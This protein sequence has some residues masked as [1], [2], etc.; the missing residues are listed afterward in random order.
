MWGGLPS[1][2][3]EERRGATAAFLTVFGVLAAHTIL[4]TARDALFLARLPASQLPWVYLL[5]AAIAVALAQT[6][7]GGARRTSGRYGLS[8]LL[9][10]FSIPTFVFWATA[11]W[12]SPAALYALYVWTGLVGSLAVLEFYMVL[13]ETYTVTQAKRI[14]RVVGMGSLLGAVAG[15]VVANVLSRSLSAEALVPAAAMTLALTGLGPALLLRHAQGAPAP[16]RTSA[17]LVRAWSTT[18]H[19]PYVRGLAVLMLI[20][21]V[22]LTLTDYVFKSAVARTVKPTDLGSFFATVYMVLNA[23][24]I[25]VQVVL[26]GWLFRVLGLHR[27]L[28][29]LPVLLFMGSVGVALGGG[30]VA[31]LVLKGADGSL[32]NS[33]HRTGTEL[34]YLPL[35][36]GLRS[37][38]KPL[39]DVVGQRG[40]QALASLLILS[41]SSLNRGDGVLAAASA[42]LSLVWVAWTADLK[43]HYLDLFRA[44]LR[45]GSIGP[46]PDLPPLDLGSLETLF[47]AL[48]SPDDAEV[49]GAMDLLAEEGRA[50]LIPALILHHPSRPVV[51]RA[52]V[53]FS[54]SARTDFLP[55]ADRLLAHP[56]AEVRAAALRART[57]VMSDQAAL[58]SG[59]SDSSP[60]VQ[61][62]ALV[63]L[64]S[65]GWITDETQSTLDTLLAS[66]SPEASAALARAI[67]AQPSPLF[68]DVLL[69]LAEARDETVQRQVAHAMGA[70]G[71]ARFFPALLSMVG[72]WETR[73]AARDALLAHGKPA[74]EFLSAA[75]A[76]EALPH[77]V[78]RHL[79]MTIALFPPVEAAP[80]LLRRLLAEP[81]GMVR[82]K[83]LR[84]LNRVGQ[85]PDVVL[86]PAILREATESTLQAAFRLTDWRFSLT[87]GARA[88]PRRKTPG[89]DLLVTLLRDKEVHA[90]ERLF[91]L[92]ALQFRHEDFKGIYRSLWNRSPKVRASSRE[93]LENL[94]EPPLRGA[95]LALVDDAP[96]AERLRRGAPLYTPRPLDY[97][98]LLALI[99]EQPGESLRCIAAY[100]VGELG[101][102]ALRPRLEKLKP[103]PETGFFLA[104]VVERAL[105]L[106]SRSEG[107]ALAQAR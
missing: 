36:D 79:P 53:H 17:S 35:P 49:M 39:I 94:I 89:H 10:A 106:L 84:G 33:L 62:T 15:A 43:S 75:L 85:H 19:H 32:R 104:R 48:N 9:V 68:E 58:R 42:A 2:R 56:D 105:D 23:L 18:R 77:E 29:A 99:L 93:L 101:L 7:W 30:L 69:K 24:A 51:L 12:R 90:V 20:S 102:T 55:V 76:E 103:S 73:A 41:E 3:P 21:T 45:A 60:L 91:R 74:L 107:G 5:I 37:R 61:A 64:V 71:N 97:E 27:A 63:G 87:E 38:A 52:L 13:G 11:S 6:P 59:M 88:E 83:I 86:D 47:N 54:R 31:A 98:S 72:Q 80:I 40:G 92:L 95:L 34:L 28:W 70:V 16:A 14:Y 65:A 8:L 57:T 22:V 46:R 100:H 67:R 4:E 44:A 66:G 82:F 1:I 25:G 96:D 81:D 78:R 26:T 50:H